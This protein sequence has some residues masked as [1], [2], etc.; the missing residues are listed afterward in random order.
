MYQ[1]KKLYKNTT[2]NEFKDPKFF[3]KAEQPKLT[4]IKTNAR[5]QTI[6]GGKYG[7]NFL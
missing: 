4:N 1:V 2:K 5:I 3:K 6:Y 7:N